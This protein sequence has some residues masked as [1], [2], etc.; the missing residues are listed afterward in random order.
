MESVFLP[1]VQTGRAD[2]AE[3][4][5]THYGRCLRRRSGTVVLANQEWLTEYETECPRLPRVSRQ[6]MRRPQTCELKI[7][8]SL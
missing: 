4:Q 5:G 3:H 1:L 8:G 2:T 7:A 6:I